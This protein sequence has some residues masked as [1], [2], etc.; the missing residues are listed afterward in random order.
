MHTHRQ[1]LRKSTGV[2]QSCL[3]SHEHPFSVPREV[4]Y[5]MPHLVTVL[6][7]FMSTWCHG[8]ENYWL[9]ICL[10]K[11]GLWAS[12]LVIY[13][14]FFLVSDWCGRAQPTVGG[15]NPRLMVLGAIRNQAEQTRRSK[16]VRSMLLWSLLQFLLPGWCLDPSPD[17]LLCD[18]LWWR[19]VSWNKSL[20]SRL[21]FWLWG[22]IGAVRTL[23]QSP[24]ILLFI[25]LYFWYLSVSREYER[26]PAEFSS[27]KYG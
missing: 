12:L 11:I 18:G 8:E 7:S 21:L 5:T 23:K 25:P 9:R 16:P 17:F 14:F 27:V 20:S 15:A 2:I 24:Y 3:F 19:H 6:V 13:F 26:V 10:R 4:N 22:F 1:L